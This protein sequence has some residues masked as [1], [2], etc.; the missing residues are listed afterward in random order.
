MIKLTEPHISV[1]ALTMDKDNVLM[2]KRGDPPYENSWALPGGHLEFGEKLE[3]AAVR[4]TFEET[5]I[6]VMVDKFISFKNVIVEENGRKFHFVA[7]CYN[8]VYL[9]GT[10]APGSD[11]RAASWVPIKSLG[12]LYISPVVLDFIESGKSL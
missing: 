5:G 8:A 11:V 2:I 9:N 10:L 3:D 1:L 4:E 7:F 6:R 12:N